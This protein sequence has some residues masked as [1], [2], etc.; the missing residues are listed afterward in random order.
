MSTHDAEGRYERV[1]SLYENNG[2]MLAS[3]AMLAPSGNAR[4]ALVNIIDFLVSL[5][6]DEI[7]ID[8]R[9]ILEIA[10]R[11]LVLLGWNSP[12]D[13]AHDDGGPHDAEF[14][15]RGFEDF[16]ELTPEETLQAFRRELGLA[17]DEN[18]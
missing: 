14:A 4:V 12:E 11:G 10:T 7:E 16:S 8:K 3:L 15:A 1:T 17:D 9:I 6:D 5:G 2:E 13:H 18:N